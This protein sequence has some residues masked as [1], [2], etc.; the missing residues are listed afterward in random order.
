MVSAVFSNGEA[1]LFINGEQVAQSD[2]P[3]DSL[4]ILEYPH[5]DLFLG[6]LWTDAYY[7]YSFDGKIDEVRIS[8]I[9]RY[10]IIPVGV[11]NIPENSPPSILVLG[12]NFPNPFNPSTTI[13]WQQPETGLVTLIIYDVLGREVATLVNEESSAGEHETVFD[14]LRLSSGIYFYQLQSG[15]FIK[16]KKMI[17][18]K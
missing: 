16:T 5:D 11:R 8:N 6:D 17:L 15:E 7:P 2:V 10:Q 3:F 13:R 18:L 14:A 1:G 12:Q 4:T 9:A